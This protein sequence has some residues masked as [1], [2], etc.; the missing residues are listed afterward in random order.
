MS[1]C[2]NCRHYLE[3]S[4]KAKGGRCF[5]LE[6]NA[7]EGLLQLGIVR[8]CRIEVFRE[9]EAAACDEYM[10]TLPDEIMAHILGNDRE[11][12]RRPL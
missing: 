7:A 4:E 2:K 10:S 8:Q 6:G 11:E 3:A 9:A 5:V 12:Q 1:T